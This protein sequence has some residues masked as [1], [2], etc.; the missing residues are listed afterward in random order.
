VASDHE[1]AFAMG[2]FKPD[3]FRSFL[4]GFGA[5]AVVMAAQIVPQLV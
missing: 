2:L 5:T 1:K 4:L 3:F